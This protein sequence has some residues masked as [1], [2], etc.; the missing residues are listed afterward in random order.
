MDYGNGFVCCGSSFDT[1]MKCKII[2]LHTSI[3]QPNGLVHSLDAVH[4][5][6]ILCEYAKRMLAMVK[7]WFINM[8]CFLYL[9][10]RVWL[11]F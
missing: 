4:A 8:V 9:F 5:H 10:I 1:V 7:V 11:V 3:T 2:D 6:Q